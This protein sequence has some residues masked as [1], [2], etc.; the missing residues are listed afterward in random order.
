MPRG[1]KTTPEGKQ[2]V[3]VLVDSDTVNHARAMGDLMNVDYRDLIARAAS[4]HIEEQYSVFRAA[5][6]EVAAK[7]GLSEA[8]IES[9]TESPE[10]PQ[11]NAEPTPVL[12]RIKHQEVANA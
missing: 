10:A 2:N 9:P 12:R 11:D 5:L 1:I 3:T 8:A 7:M 4:S 6:G